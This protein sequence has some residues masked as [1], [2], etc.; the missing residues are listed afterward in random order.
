MLAVLVVVG[1]FVVPAVYVRGVYI[2]L[3]Q[4]K[5]FLV[6]TLIT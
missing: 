4:S 5:L 1:D 3:V 2:R 6:I